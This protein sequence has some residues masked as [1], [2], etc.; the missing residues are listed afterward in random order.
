MVTEIVADELVRTEQ[1]K[2]R[3]GVGEGTQA[4]QRHPGAHADHDLF[5][6][7]GVDEPIGK[8]L[9]E[10][11]N[12]AGGRDVSHDDGQPL[13]LFAGFIK[14]ISEGIPHDAISVNPAIAWAYSS[15]LGER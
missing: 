4:A 12:R 3:D 15:L 5:G 10:F 1:C 8:I 7:A 2:G 6:D 11:L 13:V 14:G 9:A